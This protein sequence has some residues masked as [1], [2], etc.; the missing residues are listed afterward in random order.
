M[1]PPMALQMLIENATKHNE[2]SEEFPL[3]IRMWINNGKVVVSNNLQ[4]R[5][6][7]EV[8]C[9][10]GLKNIQQRYHFFTTE[11]VRIEETKEAF[12]VELPLLKT[13]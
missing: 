10:T 12:T 8:S 4:L 6:N 11:E 5:S 9:K 13:I 1:L 2:I 3:T 7:P